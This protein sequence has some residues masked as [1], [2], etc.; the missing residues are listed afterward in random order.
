MKN[1]T[2]FYNRLALIKTVNT[3]R[4]EE[5]NHAAKRR[6]K[7]IWDRVCAASMGQNPGRKRTGQRQSSHTAA[8][9]AEG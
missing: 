7:H 5:Q 3:Q 1:C 9:Q 6:H 4:P 2:I 8:R